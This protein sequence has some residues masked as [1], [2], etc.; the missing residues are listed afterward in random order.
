MYQNSI[1][2]KYLYIGSAL[3][4]KYILFGYMDSWGSDVV[5]LKFGA[6]RFGSEV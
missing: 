4:P 3:R 6:A 1:V 5:S 2:P